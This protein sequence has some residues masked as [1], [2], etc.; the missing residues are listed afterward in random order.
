MNFLE[1]AVRLREETGTSGTGPITVANQVGEYKRLVNW[2]N[3]A[4]LDVQ[5]KWMDWRFLWK[6]STVTMV[7]T[8]SDYSLAADCV[9]PNEDSFYID[10]NKL[11]PIDFDTYRRDRGAF[12]DMGTGTPQYFTIMPNEKIRVFPTPAATG[13]VLNYEY[14]RGGLQMSGN[15]DL[16]VIPA[17]YH[18]VILWK[19]VMMWAAFENADVELKVG[20]FNYDAAMLRL[21]ANQLP[22]REFAHGRVQGAEIVVCTE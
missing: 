5:N 1:L 7:I 16:P 13:A 8:T 6:E 9:M 18:D 4:Y 17:R 10:G 15:T 21:E 20:Q 2:V 3:Q 22:S 11:D 12:D 19:A 14:Q